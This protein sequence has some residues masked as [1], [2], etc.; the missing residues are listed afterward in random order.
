MDEIE[1]SIDK[2]PFY[3]IEINDT[4]NAE[5]IGSKFNY[6]YYDSCI[7]PKIR[8]TERIIYFNVFYNILI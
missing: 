8:G 6:C 2:M 4:L 7:L 3:H 5:I 1:E